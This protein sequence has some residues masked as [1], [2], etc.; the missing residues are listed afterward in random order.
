MEE[1]SRSLN[2]LEKDGGEVL[3]KEGKGEPS[4]VMEHLEHLYSL[5][6]GGKGLGKSKGKGKGEGRACHWCGKEGH[7]KRF[8]PD[9]DKVM[10]EWRAQGGGKQG[11]KGWSNYK[12]NGKGMGK[13]GGKAWNPNKGGGQG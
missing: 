9:L 7:I 13:D 10:Q 5:V 2:S 8:C 3:V 12:G 4:T 6:T 11:T 1:S